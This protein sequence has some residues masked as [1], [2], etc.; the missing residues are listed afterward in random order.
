MKKILGLVAFI[1]LAATVSIAQNM[2][3]GTSIEDQ[4]MMH[5]Q[6]L[7]A[8][9]IMLSNP[10]KERGAIQYVPIHFHLVADGAGNG[11]I[12][13]NRILDQ[14][15]DLNEAYAPHDIQFYINPHPTYGL[16]NKSI[17]HDN[18]YN[19]QTNTFLMQNRRH[20]N[21]LNVFVAEVAST[22]T[23]VQP[24]ITLAYYS[25]TRDWVVSRKDQI[26]GAGN[27]TLPHEI[28]HFFTLKH[29]HYGW[30]DDPNDEEQPQ[31][32][33]TDPTWPIAPVQA[34]SPNFVATTER[35]DGTNCLSAADGICDTPPDY[36]FGY[37]WNG[38]TVYN[39]PAKDPLGVLVNPMETNFMGYF[40]GCNNYEFTPQQAGVV[41]ANIN[42]PGRNYLD[43]T[44]QPAATTITVPTN[45]LV[46][47]I[48]GTTT[49]FYN[50]VE[51][52][53][54]K[55]AGSTYYLVE[56]DVLSSFITNSFKSYVV[57]DTTLQIN[58]LLPNKTYYWRVRP[59]NPSYTCTNFRQASFKT[60]ADISNVVNISALN[61]LKV[62]PNPV[63]NGQVAL[64][65]IEANAGFEAT[66]RLVDVAGRITRDLGTIPFMA[67][68]NT[69]QL[70]T[71]ALPNGVYFVVLDTEKGRHTERLVVLR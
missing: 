33:P 71:D 28:G 40:I 52:T 47:P 41:S 6:F 42:S 14:L 70:D 61:E 63:E 38:C 13:E 8:R 24:G 10:V 51:L 37:S 64:I 68:E 25:P 30:E 62:T 43:N 4:A 26:N 32:E 16:F 69:V 66:L 19:N 35:V 49:Q 18:V 55:V 60:S 2:R 65:Q 3:C 59:F 36:N 53:W 15:C 9:S 22:G 48:G 17:N 45:L 1:A 57:T 46:A 56:T 34:P 5:E 12:K 23:S 7:E 21:A 31:F 58:D 27:G 20:N 67:G 11:R 29:T 50:D 54:N 44:Y 39:L